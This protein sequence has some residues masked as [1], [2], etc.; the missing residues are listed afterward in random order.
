MRPSFSDPRSSKA[1]E[2]V[3]IMRRILEKAILGGATAQPVNFGSNVASFN[4]DRISA[5]NGSKGG[6]FHAN[7]DRI[8]YSG[9]ADL[10]LYFNALTNVSTTRALT[11]ADEHGNPQR[12][13]LF[14]DGSHV[15]GSIEGSYLP[16]CGLLYSVHLPV[17][18]LEAI[19]REEKPTARPVTQW[20]R[21]EKEFRGE[22]PATEAKPAPSEP[23]SL[24]DMILHALAD[25]G[26]HLSL[27]THP[28][29]RLTV[30]VTLRTGR[31]VGVD[32]RCAV[33]HTVPVVNEKGRPV[34][35][36]DFTNTFLSNQNVTSVVG[37]KAANVNSGNRNP[38][39]ADT[40]LPPS[41][42][43]RGATDANKGHDNKKQAGDYVLLGDLHSKQGKYREAVT[44]YQKAIELYQ[45]ALDARGRTGEVNPQL[46]L[47][48]T[49][50]KLIQAQ[51]AGGQGDEALTS[52][53]MLAELSQAAEKTARQERQA[54]RALT[55]DNLKKAA[56]AAERDPGSALPAKFTVTVAKESLDAYHAGRLDFD[57][58]K[59][60]A[61]V[62]L[63][64]FPSVKK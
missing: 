30:A 41:D 11:I 62:D 45:K 52:L 40:D 22:K 49:Y 25:N 8:F 16:G 48:E 6:D 28:A 58:F 21:F 32:Q 53:K 39:S 24:G 43:L 51:T 2:E 27:F 14:Q 4:F 63:I 34:P 61:R 59:K 42:P 23:M 31:E 12:A 44:A 57:Q 36:T 18:Y 19:K 1:A 55:A 47:V 10:P 56:S 37:N 26:H 3:E 50:S 46:N 35:N 64:M 54:I 5:S 38:L 29:D 17:H 33:C 15:S 13:Y 7:H 9:T 60:G 20:E